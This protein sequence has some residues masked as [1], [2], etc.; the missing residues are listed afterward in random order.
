MYD[1]IEIF[2]KD[3]VMTINKEVFENFVVSILKFK[4][5]YNLELYKEINGGEIRLRVFWVIQ[6]EITPL[7]LTRSLKKIKLYY[8]KQI[9]KDIG[10]DI[11]CHFRLVHITD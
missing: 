8:V 2:S 7:T 3:Y 1:N 9:E 6:G 10:F 4:R 5:D 11:Q